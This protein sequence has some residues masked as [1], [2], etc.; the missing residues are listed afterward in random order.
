MTVPE[1][2]TPT[3]RSVERD[4]GRD[5]VVGGV[6]PLD[7]G[8]YV[9]RSSDAELFR[10]AVAGEY[11]H[12]TAPRQSGKSSLTARVAERL[13]ERGHRVAVVDTSQ[14]GLRQED[15]D[16]ARWFYSFAFRLI[17]QLR[18]RVDLQAWWQDNAKLTNRQR[19]TELYWD[20]ILANTKEPVTIFV[21]SPQPFSTLPFA[22][23]LLASIRAVHNARAA[24][25]EMGRLNFVLLSVGDAGHIEEDSDLQLLSGSQNVSIAPFSLRELRPLRGLLHA[26]P[27]VARRF[28]KR[29]HFW[30]GG[31]P[32]LT[33][34][35]AR[36]VARAKIPAGEE[37]A[38]V[39][40]IVKQLFGHPGVLHSEPHLNAI[41]QA[42][43]FESGD[44]EQALT[45]YGRVRKGGRVAYNADSS[46]HRT[47]IDE[48]VLKVGPD[49]SLVVAN[50]TYAMAFTTRWVNEHLDLNL[51]VAV[52][53]LAGIFLVFV[54]P[55][56]Y[57]Q[58]MPERWTERITANA[59]ITDATDAHERLR[60][61]PGHRQRA[62]QLL[63]DA[64]AE[65]SLASADLRAV[66][67][68]D[69][70]L[71]ELP[72]TQARANELLA[73]YWDRTAQHHEA[74]EKRDLALL[75]RVNAAAITAEPDVSRLSAVAALVGRDY[76]QLLL[77]ARFERPVSAARITSSGDWLVTQQDLQFQNRQI[78][79]ASQTEKRDWAARALTTTQ[80]V[81]RLNVPSRGVAGRISLQIDLQHDRPSDLE[82]RLT[83]PSGRSAVLRGAGGQQAEPGRFRFTPTNAAVLTDLAAEPIQGS[84]TLSL[85]DTMPSIAGELSGWQLR[86]G[87]G[88]TANSV[89]EAVVLP[90]PQTTESARALLSPS[91][92]FAVALP[93]T[94]SGLAQ[95]WEVMDRQPVSAFPFNPND[96]V[97][98][99][100]LEERVILVSTDNGLRAY[101][102]ATGEPSWAP[103][104]GATPRLTALANNRQFVA[105]QTVEADKSSLRVYDLI[106]E[107]R[108]RDFATGGEHQLLAV[109][110]D[111]AAV[112]AADPD[113]TV[114]VWRGSSVAPSREYP[115][116]A[117]VVALNFNDD[118][119]RLAIVT[120][121]GGLWIRDVARDVEHRFLESPAGWQV[122]FGESGRVSMAGSSSAGY[123]AFVEDMIE[124]ATGFFRPDMRAANPQLQLLESSSEVLLFSEADRA[125]KVFRLPPITGSGGQSE[126]SFAR[127]SADA[128]RIAFEVEPG[129]LRFVLSRDLIDMSDP[130]ASTI[131]YLGHPQSVTDLVFSADSEFA[132]S[133]AVDG[134]IR[135]W[136]TASGEPLPYFIRT[137]GPV[138][139]ALAISPD[140][141][142]L[143]VADEA[144]LRLLD[145][146]TGQSVAERQTGER[147]TSL[148]F[149]SSASVMY[150]ATA[151]GAVWRLEMS[152]DPRFEIRQFRDHSITTLAAYEN[153][154]AIGYDDGAIDII[155]NWQSGARTLP[156]ANQAC[157]ELAWNQR[158]TALLC[159][160]DSW[161]REIR[162]ARDGDLR[163]RSR[164]LPA[165]R[166][167]AGFGFG[168]E[169]GESV[170]LLEATPRLAL[171]RLYWD[172][173]ELEAAALELDADTLAQIRSRFL[174][175]RAMVE[176]W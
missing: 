80:V 65:K 46:V 23:E 150:A 88:A 56:W 50:R 49:D 123:R 14:I 173:R 127:L 143:V 95:V 120:E 94:E 48:G 97:L 26:S 153:R 91:A 44:R 31:Q 89:I 6:I 138:V 27:E 114:R 136:R 81:R 32:F 109:A 70:L 33:Q 71:R 7:R 12:V 24:E 73:R 164:L 34:K 83:A 149:G 47:L 55:Y 145:L 79:S 96:R 92:R 87:S 10:L 157:R 63:A 11:A 3:A 45:L 29:I 18:L 75:A 41:Q 141:R 105:I 17:R 128:A 154:L 62:N 22:D 86:F 53:A 110:N 68:Y 142:W 129:E 61:F 118:G 117:P 125:L 28:I 13:R 131:S 107:R 90:N 72:A 124:P 156:L 15:I 82:L 135:V 113:Q 172:R 77:A 166:V 119:S 78:G 152:A 101:A 74:Q 51:K 19:L 174:V 36:R 167:Y 100:V 137:D 115:V 38:G 176:T 148:Y 58:I 106:E 64:L 111:G 85:I 133:A 37:S 21:D 161:M 165:S 155:D 30:T 69:R 39:D 116:S 158:G 169:R 66:R 108:A 54:L 132:V 99:F 40:K 160:S 151:A 16:A 130:V 5:F 84:W 42:L 59:E 52:A 1:N 98:G 2:T 134:S 102:L 121:D 122:V 8:L 20:L 175:P 35:L 25:P 103:A 171:R 170:V 159:R 162:L 147:V 144:R 112:A 57:T 146:E 9:P 126:F 60:A 43:L 140:N 67:E 168:D 163:V 93:T 4:P 76:D 104:P 139:D